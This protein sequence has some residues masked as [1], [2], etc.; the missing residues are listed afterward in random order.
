MK[1]KS[2]FFLI[3]TLLI[4]NALFSQNN[5]S[6]NGNSVAFSDAETAFITNYFRSKFHEQAV[7]YDNLVTESLEN[8]YYEIFLGK[9]FNMVPGCSFSMMYDKSLIG[10]LGEP[11]SIYKFFDVEATGGGTEYWTDIYAL[12]LVNGKPAS[13]LS[14]EIPCPF[15]YPNRCSDRPMLTKIDKNI[16]LINLGFIAEHDGNCCPSWEYEVAY[17]FQSNKLTLIS[18]RKVKQL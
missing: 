14:L 10:S 5:A 16:L 18:K 11:N 6:S 7:D 17:K 8:G 1:F 2:T 13:V 4:P 15:N 9:E 3:A 12:K